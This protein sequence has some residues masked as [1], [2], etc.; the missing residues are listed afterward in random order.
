MIFF[1]DI[2]YM[3]YIQGG[4]Y[5]R[6]N[7][8]NGNAMSVQ[9]ARNVQQ[10]AEAMIGNDIVIVNNQKRAHIETDEVINDAMLEN[11]VK[12]ANKSLAAYD[13]AIE[14][15]VHEKTHTIMYVLKDTLT[16]EIIREFPPRKIQDMIAKMWEMAGILVDERR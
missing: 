13:R 15:T 3:E 4:M 2:Y 14:R 7:S 10:P 16:N 12:E 8:M 6:I 1:A 5:M 9:D 11:S